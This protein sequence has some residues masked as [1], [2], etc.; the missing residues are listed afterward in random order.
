VQTKTLFF[1]G[2]LLAEWP[3]AILLDAEG[4]QVAR[5]L[6][7]RHYEA[8][9]PGIVAPGLYRALHAPLMYPALLRL[10]RDLLLRRTPSDVPVYKLVRHIVDR[11]FGKH[12]PPDALAEEIPFYPGARHIQQAIAMMER[13][14]QASSLREGRA[15]VLLV[16]ADSNSPV[17][18][19]PTHLLAAALAIVLRTYD[20]LLVVI[21][22][23]Y[24]DITAAE[25]LRSALL[26][27]FAGRVVTLPGEPKSSLLETAAL[28]DQAYLLVTGDT[29]VMHLAATTK[30]VRGVGGPVA[31]RNAVK[32]IA[33]FGGSNP[34]VWGY[35][36]HTTILGRGRKEQRTFRP[37][38]VKE[39]YHA[40]G[41][42]F[43][44]HIAPQQLSE[45]IAAQAASWGPLQ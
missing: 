11:H 34:D 10:G 12:T 41:T 28:I 22:P 7:E 43:F 9:F 37:G 2:P 33:L 24:S 25:R 31:P 6:R 36:Q 16:A 15:R 40:R 44:D 35:P 19:P 17:T 29:G 26:P 4:A 1:A 18:R 27:D 42:D 3:R 8:I 23:G 30:R 38:F 5:M 20:N 45:A 13:I 21:L 14:K 39:L 32:I